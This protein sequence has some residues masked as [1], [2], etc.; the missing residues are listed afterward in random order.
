MYY[1]D[2]V[3]LAQIR[4]R[5]ALYAERSGNRHLQPAPLLAQLADQG[6]GFSEWRQSQAG[7]GEKAA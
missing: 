5:L 6:S 2:G 4:D 7:K 3:G 1:A